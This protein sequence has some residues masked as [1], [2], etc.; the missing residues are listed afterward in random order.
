[1]NPIWKRAFLPLISK[2]SGGMIMVFYTIRI[3]IWRSS[4]LVEAIHG[5][6]DAVQRH[7]NSSFVDLMVAAQSPSLRRLLNRHAPWDSKS[8]W[9]DRDAKKK[10]FWKGCTSQILQASTATFLL[11]EDWWVHKWN[12]HRFMICNSKKIIGWFWVNHRHRWCET[13]HSRHARRNEILPKIQMCRFGF[14]NLVSYCRRRRRRRHHHH[15]H[16]SLLNIW[17]AY[18]FETCNFLNFNM[19]SPTQTYWKRLQ[20]HANSPHFIALN[21]HPFSSS[22]PPI[23]PFL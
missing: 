17:F 22:D 5:T 6:R 19:I 2:T 1:M 3:I 11:H 4:F 13:T 8:W 16:Q 21:F 12:T 20:K 14:Q 7:W 9:S 10:R 23:R 18:N 15:H